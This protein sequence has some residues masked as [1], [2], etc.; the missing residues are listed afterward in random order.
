VSKL[1]GT[2]LASLAF[3]L[4]TAISHRS[5][6]LPFLYVSI[7]VYDVIYVVMV[8]KQLQAEKRTLA[9]PATPT[10]HVELSL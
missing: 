4:Y 8:Y 6:L 10:N 3:F 5:V 7:L 2:A 9:E 1:L